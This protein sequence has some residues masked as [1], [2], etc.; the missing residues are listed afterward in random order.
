[1]KTKNKFTNNMFNNVF[2]GGINERTISFASKREYN[3]I[4]H[5]VEGGDPTKMLT[6][7]TKKD[8]IYTMCSNEDYTDIFFDIV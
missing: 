1:M 5:K 6:D 8:E 4:D 3:D 7:P 2:N